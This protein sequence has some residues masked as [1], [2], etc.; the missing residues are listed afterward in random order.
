MESLEANS[1]AHDDIAP[2][3]RRVLVAEKYHEMSTRF[4]LIRMGSQGKAGTIHRPTTLDKSKAFTHFV[5]VSDIAAVSG[6][7]A[8][9]PMPQRP[10]PRSI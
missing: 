9:R 1:I 3:K 7:P 2:A 5:A 4:R 10:S 6:K 8:I